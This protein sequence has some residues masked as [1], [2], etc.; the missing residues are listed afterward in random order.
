MALRME[1]EEVV[2]QG[3]AIS[4]HSQDV[5]DLQTWLNSVVNEQLP[6]IWEGRGYEG[7]ATR[8]AELAPTFESMRQLI[9]EI[10]NAVVVKAQEYRD[11]DEANG[12]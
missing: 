3:Q 8:V 9:E 7:F 2:Q 12:K 6:A 11:F 4:S 10:G 5:T 1:F